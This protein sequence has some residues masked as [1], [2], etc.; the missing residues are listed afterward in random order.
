MC[1]KWVENPENKWEMGW[2]H[3]LFQSEFLGEMSAL[4]L[5]ELRTLT[6]FVSGHL[7]EKLYVVHQSVLIIWDNFLRF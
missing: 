4:T 5:N 7:S 2:V 3:S 1:A 6:K